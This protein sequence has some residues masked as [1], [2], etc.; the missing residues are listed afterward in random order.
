MSETTEP[1]GR[2]GVE[3]VAKIS[4]SKPGRRD[5][6]YTRLFNDPDI[7]ALVSRVQG[8]SIRAGNELEKLFCENLK[9]TVLR[10]LT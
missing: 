8:T 4:E 10:L 9:T 2:L 6:G 3:V 7:G 5:G 1:M